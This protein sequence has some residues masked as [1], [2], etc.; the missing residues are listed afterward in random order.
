MQIS[1][2]DLVI[3][4]SRGKMLAFRGA[5][6]IGLHC[7]DGTVWLTVEGKPDDL[8]LTKGERLLIESNGLAL[9]QGLP[10][11]SVQL[12]LGST[13]K[14]RRATNRLAKLLRPRIKSVNTKTE[15]SP[16]AY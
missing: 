12:V 7:T 8:V 6:N 13:R 1:L 2:G 9:I 15:L 11:G 4:L 14:R 16:T 3:H 5:R 10:S